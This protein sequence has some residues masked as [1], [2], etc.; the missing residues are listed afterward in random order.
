MAAT[1]YEIDINLP[2]PERRGR[3]L[4]ID[5]MRPIPPEALTRNGT[6]RMPLGV[7]W[8]PWGCGNVSTDASDCAVVYDLS[9]RELPDVA[10]QPAFLIWDALKCSTLSS[11]PEWLRQRVV[12][13]LSVYTSAAF[14]S[15]L[16]GAAASGGIGLVGNV[17]YAPTVVSATAVSLRNAFLGLEGAL[18]DKL[19]GGMGVIHLTPGLLTLASADDLVYWADGQYWTPTGHCVV[20]DAGFTG[21]TPYDESAAGEGETWIYATS[22]IHYAVSAINSTEVLTD[23]QHDT[24]I[25]KNLNRPIAQRYG[26]MAW[27]PCA[28][29]AILVD[30]TTADTA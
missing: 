26:I 25:L 8:L 5:A 21:A 2:G 1:G 27:D 12:D 16:Q 6:S 11:E 22:M 24:K 9:A 29:S 14:A 18:A 10:L 28:T 4:L 19:H 3:G 13:N 20:G 17:T 23:D 30:P 15:E 7:T